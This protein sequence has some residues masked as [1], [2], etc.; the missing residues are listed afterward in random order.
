MFRF[1]VGLLVALALMS[2]G[3][4]YSSKYMGGGGGAM[5]SP[6][7]TE[8]VPNNAKAGGMAFTLTVNGS[9]FGT[10]AVVYW[11]GAAQSSMYLSANQVTAQITA[12]DIM[13]PGMVPVYV[14]TGGMNSNSVTFT[15]E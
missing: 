10:D 13:S 12:S 15:V 3:C 6:T 4:G 11:N 9:G 5:G 1:S 14:R 2:A 8:L 7:I